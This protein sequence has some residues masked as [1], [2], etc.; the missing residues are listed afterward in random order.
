LE[1]MGDHAFV[2]DTIASV[3]ARGNGARRQTSAFR[4]HRDVGDVVTELAYATLQ[5]CR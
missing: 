5:G 2:T 4:A 1:E 3:F